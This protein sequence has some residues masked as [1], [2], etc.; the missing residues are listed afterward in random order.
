MSK[1]S[2]HFQNEQRK[3]QATEERVRRMQ[4]QAAALSAHDLARHTAAA[5]EKVAELEATRDLTRTWLHV[6]M[7][8]F[9]AS[10]EELDNPALAGRPFAVGGLGMISTASYAAR[11]FGVRSAMPGFIGLKLCPDLLFVSPNFDKYRTAAERTRVIFKDYD[12]DLHAAS[13]DEAFL[14]ITEFC[15][16]QMMEGE[17]Q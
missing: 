9:F 17:C 16:E 13:L 11:K 15:N 14:D 8:A 12:A 7:D 4:A 2:A 1:D 10:V 6:D 3:Q 5:D